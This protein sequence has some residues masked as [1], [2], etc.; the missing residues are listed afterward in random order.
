MD[1]TDLTSDEITTVVCHLFDSAQKP[2]VI[3]YVLTWIW[4]I[5]LRLFKY[6]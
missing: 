6:F 5:L 2:F 1:L 4:A 3:V